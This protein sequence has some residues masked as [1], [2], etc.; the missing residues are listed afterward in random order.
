MKRFKFPIRTTPW[1]SIEPHHDLPAP[2][3]EG[4]KQPGLCGQTKYLGVDKLPVVA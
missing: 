3:A 1:G 4:T 2:T